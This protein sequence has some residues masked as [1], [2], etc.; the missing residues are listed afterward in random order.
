MQL[1]QY[2]IINE[3]KTSERWIL[4]KNYKGG[5]LANE[6][7]KYKNIT[8]RTSES[9]YTGQIMTFKYIVEPN[10]GKRKK[11]QMLNNDRLIFELISE[12]EGLNYE[13]KNLIINLNIKEELLTP[14]GPVVKIR[15]YYNEM[16]IEN[17]IRKKDN[18]ISILEI[19][20]PKEFLKYLLYF[21]SIDK[22]LNKLEL[23]Q[24]NKKI[25]ELASPDSGQTFN[26]KNFITN[27]EIKGLVV[28]PGLSPPLISNSGMMGSSFFHIPDGVLYQQITSLG[29]L[30]SN[31]TQ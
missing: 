26:G 21:S 19:D 11:L 2:C 7:V 1:E 25:I 24:G 28:T 9:R 29:I 3:E 5:I 22:P 31:E 20:Y 10:I 8:I 17:W 16:L 14:N 12:N 18:D 30:T 6:D 13:G 23:Y 27:E 15:I 4:I